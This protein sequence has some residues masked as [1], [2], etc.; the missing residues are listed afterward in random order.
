MSQ[1]TSKS[2]VEARLAE[3]GLVLPETPKPMANYVGVQ[4]SG[5]LLFTS[6]GGPLESGKP[7]YLGKVGEELSL[8][9]GQDAARRTALYLLSVLKAYLG[10][11]D[12]IEQIV[13]VLGF[14]A[15]APGFYAQPKVMDGFS[16]TMVAVLGD[17]G[18]HARSAVA[19]PQLPFN[20]PVEVE[21]VV[22]VSD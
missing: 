4:R 18:K 19:V 11:L 14:V 21:M 8:E 7:V 1:G 20:T 2:R 10:D 16:D 17:R 13:K 6:G 12:R 5:D 3:M 9:Q 22:R 15:S